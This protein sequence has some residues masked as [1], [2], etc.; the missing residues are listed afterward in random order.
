M[1]L[2]W[3]CCWLFVLTVTNQASSD[4]PAVSSPPVSSPPVSSPPVS[5]PPVSSSA[6]PKRVKQQRVSP[7]L[8]REAMALPEYRAQAILTPSPLSTVP[9]QQLSEKLKANGDLENLALLEQLLRE[10]QRLSHQSAHRSMAENLFNLRCEVIEVDLKQIPHDSV[11]RAN[12]LTNSD[13]GISTS[14]ISTSGISIGID[15][16]S[17]AKIHLALEQTLKSRQGTRLFEPVTL[18]AIAAETV[19][20]HQGTRLALPSSDGSSPQGFQEIG[21][22]IDAKVN[23]TENDFYRVEF[24]IEISHDHVGGP[25][26][27]SPSSVSPSSVSPPNPLTPTYQKQQTSVLAKSGEVAIVVLP[28]GNTE[29]KVFLVTT[30]TPRKSGN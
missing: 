17:A 26:S 23:P 10:H 19:H 18:T 14:G 20:F 30:V 22:I 11:L 24:A 7:K 3:I 29:Q 2:K 4:D 16:E 25:S 27:V 28:W 21:T 5:S 8:L 9:L 15:P 6:I 12:N 1:L 13:S